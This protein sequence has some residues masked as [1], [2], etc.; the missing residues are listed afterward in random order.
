MSNNITDEKR[1]SAPKVT[2]D[3]PM[4]RS[5]AIMSSPPAMVNRTNRSSLD[6]KKPLYQTHFQTKLASPSDESVESTPWKVTK[7]LPIPPQYRMDR[8]HIK[9]YDSALEVS[10]RI[11][12][13]FFRESI[14]AIYDNEEVCIN[15]VLPESLY[16]FSRKLTRF[17]L[18]FC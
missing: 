18:I 14:A 16:L 13:C 7:A 12:D 5:V 1:L 9:V 2:E 11:A 17:V 10:K 4:M 15:R 3:G 8:S 6:S